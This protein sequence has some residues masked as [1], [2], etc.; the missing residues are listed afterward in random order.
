M[1]LFQLVLKRVTL[2]F[3][4]VAVF[5]GLIIS[6][7]FLISPLLNAR[8]SNL[9]AWASD[10]LQMPVTIQQARMSWHYLQPG[11]SLDNVV[12]ENKENKAPILQV[13][14]IK[15]FLSIT[16][17]LWRL[18]F[19]PSDVRLSGSEVNLVETE[20]NRITL[21]GLPDLTSTQV[22]LKPLY[23]PANLLGVLAV[24]PAIRLQNIDIR[25]VDL[26]GKKLFLTLHDLHFR[27]RPYVHTIQGKAILHQEKPTEINTMIR[28]EGNEV[29]LDKLKANLYVELTGL[30]LPQWLQTRSFAGLSIL[31]G[32]GNAK[33]WGTWAG[34]SFSQ[35]KS[36]FQLADLRLKTQ[37]Q[38]PAINRFSGTIHWQ[39]EANGLQ[40]LSGEDILLDFSGSPWPLNK[41]YLSFS[42]ND[43][44]I[45]PKVMQ[46]SYLN[47][48]DIAPL[49]LQTDLLSDNTRHYLSQHM[50]RG[51]L[52]NVS[53]TF[54]GPMNDLRQMSFAAHLDKISIIPWERNSYLGN[55]TGDIKWNGQQGEFLLNS[56]RFV[57]RYDPFFIKPINFAELSGRGT[58]SLDQ[59][60]QWIIQTNGVHISNNDLTMDL[61]GGVTLPVD[62]LP[63]T[64]L[65]ADFAIPNAKHI[66]QYLPLKSFSPEL[67]KWLNAA[68]LQGEVRSGHLILRGIL[69]DFPFAEGKGVFSISGSVHNVELHF[70]PNWP[71][72]THIN[73]NLL[74]SGPKL[75]INADNAQISG[76]KLSRIEAH[77]PD[78]SAGEETIL[79][80][81]AEEIPSN[82]AKAFQFIHHS[83][84][85]QTIGKMFAGVELQGPFRL[86]LNLDVPLNDPK[87]TSL[88]G[89]MTLQ[90]ATLN[91]PAWDVRLNQLHGLLHFT[92]NAA[93]AKQLNAELFNKPVV[94]DINTEQ[95]DNQSVIK[96]SLTERWNLSELAKHF[97]IDLPDFVKGETQIS[98][99]FEFS[100]QT[101]VLVNLR[102]D[103]V[104]VQLDLPDHL[105]KSTEASRP[106][107]ASI[108]I[109]ENKPLRIK[110]QYGAELGAA[111]LLEKKQQEMTLSGLN[112][113]LGEGTPSWPEGKGITITGNFEQLDWAQ[114]QS[115]LNQSDSKMFSDLKVENIDI[116]AKTLQLGRQ[117]LKQVQLTLK[118]TDDQWII[119]INSP[120]V[121]GEIRAPQKFNREGH[122]S[123]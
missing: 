17:S 73:G 66:S 36:T 29:D 119:N 50:P 112:L 56:N 48:G 111:F 95:R 6:I 67:T 12:V 28:W 94:I 18:R 99:E 117:E 120:D 44:M 46:F 123:A 19:I 62:Q 106:S 42:S 69:N 100:K 25:Y 84:L 71:N 63:I 79:H 104:G 110:F 93:F 33:V 13:K 15:I 74:F 21:R 89:W 101:P 5:I 122:I 45:T 20:A 113:Q 103:L 98:S 22:E 81:K 34:G 57:F 116:R 107:A 92:E 60:N 105:A 76:I 114:I 41:F 40:I 14:N 70:A 9:E 61:K 3:I 8:K 115:Y 51:N 82:F 4:I 37:R 58:F 88:N 11:I 55:V 91:V 77:I 65:A 86:K 59:A 1:N 90:Q 35:L 109:E 2:V 75:F 96:A 121:E 47:L 16:K 39:R 24:Q 30:S 38:L 87:N 118:S 97:N 23:T 78:L 54:N 85:N 102:S 52:Q 108:S 26:T 68:F 72:L 27:N 7:S 53:A 32:E 31:Q 43:Q 83:P 80:V 49:L 10:L 64:D